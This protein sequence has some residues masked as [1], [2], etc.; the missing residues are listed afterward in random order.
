MQRSTFAL[1]IA[2][3]LV[4]SGFAHAE[5]VRK[6]EVAYSDLD[7]SRTEQASTLYSRIKRAAYAVCEVNTV[8]NPQALLLQHKCMANAVDAAV[9]SVD[10][11][12]L[13]AV[14]L[15]RS[16]KRAMVASSR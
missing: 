5:D 7:L 14:H 10:N 16:G 8:P 9:R 3:A 4:F 12:N 13:T 1:G 15:A 11:A 6:I 2:A